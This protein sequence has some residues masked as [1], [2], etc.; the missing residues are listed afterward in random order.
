[1]RTETHL[2]TQ[3]A[4]V[5]LVLWS[6]QGCGEPQARNGDRGQIYIHFT[7]QVASFAVFLPT[8]VQALIIEIVSPVS[9]PLFPWSLH[10]AQLVMSICAA[11]ECGQELDWG[12]GS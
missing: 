1:M 12:G 8:E 2:V 11:D 4:P 7:S 5:A 6:S 3:G 9:S 10:L